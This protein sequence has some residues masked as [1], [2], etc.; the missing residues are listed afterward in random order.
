VHGVPGTTDIING[1]QQVNDLGA[2]FGYLV[3]IKAA[4]VDGRGMKGGTSEDEFEAALESAQPRRGGRRTHS[5][6][7]SVA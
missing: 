2:E 5:G 1:P 7:C 4:F 3:A 6:H